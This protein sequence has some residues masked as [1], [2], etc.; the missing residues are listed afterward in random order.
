MK[1]DDV[2]KSLQ[3]AKANGV[4]NIISMWWCAEDFDVP[5][6]DDWAEAVEDVD[7]CMDWADADEE[8][9]WILNAYAPNNNVYI[10]P[11]SNETDI[12]YT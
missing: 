8:I 6:D 1:I 3:T 4:E 12:K 11:D 10:G 9:R 2:I 7:R 5:D